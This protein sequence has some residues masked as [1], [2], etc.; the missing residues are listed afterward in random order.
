MYNKF[1][2]IF[3]MVYKNFFWRYLPRHCWCVWAK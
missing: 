3:K 1:H 2:Y